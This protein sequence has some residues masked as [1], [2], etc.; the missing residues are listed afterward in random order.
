MSGLQ[1]FINIQKM[2]KPDGDVL[3]T[4]LAN[5]P[6][7]EIYKQ[8]SQQGRWHSYMNDI[9][10]FVSPYQY[11]PDPQGDLEKLLRDTGFTNIVCKVKHRIYVYPNVITLRKSITAVNPFLSGIPDN[12]KE[13]YLEDYLAEVKRMDFVET[14]NNNEEQIKVPYELFVVY[15]QK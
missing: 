13:K 14:N 9:N 11:S 6:I 12:M 8:L 5:N 4:F 15:A 2:L 3:L 7:F 10:Q 1:A